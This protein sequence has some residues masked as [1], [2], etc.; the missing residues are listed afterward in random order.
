[1]QNASPPFGQTAQAPRLLEVEGLR[2]VA[3]WSIVL[4]H[5][6]IFSSPAV[7]TWN[8]GPAT[9]LVQPLQSGVTLFFVLSGFLLYRPIAAAVVDGRNAA[10]VGRY[11]RNR[12]LRILPAYW[13]ILGV[14]VFA[15]GSAAMHATGSGVLEGRLTD[16]ATI[17]K[18]FLLIQTY[19]PNA[20]WTGIL[21]A[22][23]LTVEVAFYVLL[24]VL[25][26]A[27]GLL[28]RRRAQSGRVIAAAAPVVAMLLVGAVGKALVSIYS[29]GPQR[30]TASGWHA[31]LDRSILTH[32]DLFAFG[33]GAGL[34]LV[35]W[36]RRLGARLMPLLSGHA[37]RPLAYLGLPALFL[38]FYVLPPYVYDA[39]VAL[40]V[41]LVLL[42]LVAPQAGAARRAR[43][44]RFLTHPWTLAAGR[45]SYSVFLWNYPVLAFLT[46]HH[47]L[48]GGY[49]VATFFVNLAAASTAVVLLSAL[50]YRFVE[51]PALALKDRR[52]TPTAVSL[53]AVTPAS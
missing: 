24:P 41:A 38:G 1:M 2:A 42:R 32:A 7:L 52:T 40:L 48:L 39:V 28:A 13:V 11:L 29:A 12:A 6:W 15:F 30:A 3:A 46:V 26:L 44:N 27:A 35:L 47:L 45:R 8:L 4:F 18:D 10:S 21:P 51:V 37:A 36:E 23:S 33:M 5:C 22:W 16:P 17:A 31:V 49:G 50:T 20:V 19:D 14:V 43:T 53:P 9:P 34:V 25:A